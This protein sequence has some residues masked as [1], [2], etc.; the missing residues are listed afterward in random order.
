MKNSNDT[1]K[2]RTRVLPT[3]SAEPQPNAPPAALQPR[4]TDV[5]NLLDYSDGKSSVYCFYSV[6]SHSQVSLYV[7]AYQIAFCM[8]A[9][10]CRLPLFASHMHQQNNISRFC[11]KAKSLTNF[12]NYRRGP[13]RGTHSLKFNC[14]SGLSK[15]SQER[16]NVR[17][18]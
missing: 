13:L 17:L 16:T 9:A 12:C 8:K 15:P 18:K 3:C 6:L 1:I 10:T 14:K 5:A 2:N 4:S 7:R 11:H